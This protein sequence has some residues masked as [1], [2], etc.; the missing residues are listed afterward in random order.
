MLE[1]FH[2]SLRIIVSFSEPNVDFRRAREDMS[3]EC[4]LTGF[5]HVILLMNTNRVDPDREGAEL[6]KEMLQCIVAIFRHCDRDT[7]AVD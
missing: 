6:E 4:N 3:H 1:L 2:C 7:F 5:F